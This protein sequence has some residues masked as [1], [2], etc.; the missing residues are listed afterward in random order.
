M[1]KALFDQREIQFYTENV[2][3]SVTNS[4]PVGEGGRLGEAFYEKK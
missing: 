1:S 2:V 3:E 4:M